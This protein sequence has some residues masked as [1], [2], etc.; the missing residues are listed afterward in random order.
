MYTNYITNESSSS[1]LMDRKRKRSSSGLR[2]HF[3]T[4][5]QEII[6]TYS[7]SEYNRSG[8]FPDYHQDNHSSKDFILTLSFGFLSP[9]SSP[10]TI[11]TK[12]A[13]VDKK[14]KPKL[15][16]DTSTIHDGPL[17]FTNMT[18]NHQKKDQQ[19]QHQLMTP[20]DDDD[21]DDERTTLENTEINRRC[22]VTAI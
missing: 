9:P 19:Q 18:T 8:L 1:L 13:K 15:S 5:P 12:K 22:L 3:C 16:I 21:D 20:I 11:S 10:P 6:D 4:K 2:V 17:Y 14:K 7:S